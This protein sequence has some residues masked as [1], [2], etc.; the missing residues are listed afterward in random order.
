M[1]KREYRISGLPS[2]LPSIIWRYC[3]EKLSP[4][5]TLRRIGG[6]RRIKGRANTATTRLNINSTDSIAGR[7][8]FG[9][10]VISDAIN[11]AAFSI[12]NIALV[13]IPF[14]LTHPQRLN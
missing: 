1:V 4:K 14:S 3:P 7:S 11:S 13:N 5:L 9:L 2:I 8:A 12:M 10:L 6:T